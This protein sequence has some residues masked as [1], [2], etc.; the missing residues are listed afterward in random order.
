MFK[1]EIKELN[2]WFRKKEKESYFS[3]YHHTLRKDGEDLYV[4]KADDMEDFTDFLRE[5]FPDLIY[6]PCLVG[7]DGI[8][9]SPEDLKESKS[10]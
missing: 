9:F 10:Y 1:N 7:K 5:T 8:W 2:K 3:S 4:I 6:F